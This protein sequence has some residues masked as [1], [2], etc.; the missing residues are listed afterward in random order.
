MI[1]NANIT[2]G[3]SSFSELPSL[4]KE[5]GYSNP[6]F[7]VD[8]NLYDNSSYVV[9]VLEEVVNKDNLI[10]YD[11]PFEPSYQM[12]DG[13]VQDINSSKALE[14]TDVLVGIGG[15]SAMDTTKGLAILL[16]NSGSAIQYRGFPKDLKQPLP[17]IAVPSTTGTGSEVVFN[18]SF[19]DEESK[20]KMGINYELNYPILT[21]LDPLIP[22]T[23]P[24]HVLASSGCDALVHTLESFM[25][26]ES[27][28][29]VHFFSNKAY[30]LIVSNMIPLLKGEGDLNNWMNMQWASV[31]SMFALS[32]STSGPTGALSYYL[33]TNFKVNHGVAGGVFIGEV[34]KYNHE[35]GYYGLSKLYSQN[36]KHLLT[37]QEKSANII[38]QIYEI[39]NLAN[40]PEGLGS[41]GVS[42]DDL[43]GFSEFAKQAGEAFGFNPVKI[44]PN[45]IPGTL[46]NI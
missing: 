17:V 36:D 42:S 11:Y 16:K 12:L 8:K 27:N 28:E 33:G 1:I 38:K 41:F 31:Y 15:G 32:N 45:N 25:S 29:H 3:E 30:R 13:L 21:I 14:K 23:A 26:T 5:Y 6:A 43:K 44:D 46:I 24:P 18:A 7:I 20:V 10:Y 40:I 34:V 4:L 9:S 19:I 2:H 39:L 22:S 35:N 37:D